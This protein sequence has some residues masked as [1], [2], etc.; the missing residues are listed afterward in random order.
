MHVVVVLS[1]ILDPK[2]PLER[3]ASGNW[4]DTLGHPPT[5]FKLSPFDEAALEVALKLRDRDGNVSLTAVVTHGAR[6][7]ALMRTVASYRLDR[8]VGLSP[9]AAKQGDPDWLAEHLMPA[10]ASDQQTVEL[11]LIGREHGDLDDGMLPAFLA[12]TWKL[13]F[14]AL[15][16]SV[17]ADEANAWRIERAGTMCDEIYTLTGPAVVSITNAK[18]NRLRHPL[19]K[20]VMMAK[21]QK[22][23]ALTPSGESDVSRVQ[24]AAAHPP[25]AVARGTVPCEMLQGSIVEM[26]RSLADRLSPTSMES[27]EHGR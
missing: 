27:N 17:Q 8:V 5:P 6:D 14:L 19:M 11:V 15:G 13:P 26:A 7:L 12:A 23:D 3:P 9:P 24:C 4:S 22:F 2:R 10:A 20:N 18:T 21:Q 1:G 25:D 16:Q